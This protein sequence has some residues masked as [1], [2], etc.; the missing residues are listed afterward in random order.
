VNIESAYHALTRASQWERLALS[1]RGPQERSF[2]LD[3]SESLR[4]A[5]MPE[6]ALEVQVVGPFYDKQT[7]ESA[8]GGGML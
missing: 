1:T 5:A 6:N 7:S 2:R 8:A 4:R 3:P